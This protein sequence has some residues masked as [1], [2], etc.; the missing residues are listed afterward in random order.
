VP[1]DRQATAVDFPDKVQL[2]RGNSRRDL[3]N[4]VQTIDKRIV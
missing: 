1:R 3:V 4:G 2:G